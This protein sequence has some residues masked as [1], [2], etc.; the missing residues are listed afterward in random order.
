VSAAQIRVVVVVKF[1]LCEIGFP[2]TAA[3]GVSSSPSE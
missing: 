2:S 1:P 3:Y